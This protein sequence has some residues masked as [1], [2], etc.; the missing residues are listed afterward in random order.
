MK[1]ARQICAILS[2]LFLFLA[3]ASGQDSIRSFSG[4]FVVGTTGGF[5]PLA[6]N[7]AIA[8]NAD[9]IRLEPTL[10]A[11]SAERFKS[12]LARELGLKPDAPWSG[13]IILA[14]HPARSLDDEV[15]LAPQPFFRAWN[16]RVELPDV[17]DRTR[18]ARA[19]TT[20]LL[21]EIANR[22]TSVSGRSVEIPAWLADGLAQSILAGD[23]DQII[24][25]TSGKTVDG[26]PQ[27]RLDEIRHSP[28][29]LAKVHSTLQNFS[30]ATFDQ[31]SWPTDAQLDGDDGGAYHAS[32]QL[33][34]HELLELSNGAAKLRALIHDLP[35]SL[36]WQTAFFTAFH[37]DFKR[38][39]DVEKWWALR[40]VQ[41]ASRNRGPH[42]TPAASRDQLAG[43]LTVPVEFRDSSNSLPTHAEIS[44]QSAI[45]SFD[46]AQQSVVLETKLRDLAL[47]QMRMTPPFA[48]LAEGYRAALADFLMRKRASL[49][50]TLKRLDALD[51]W[52]RAAETAIK[53]DLPLP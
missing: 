33:F 32:T 44:L 28:D 6:H 48:A 41:F 38:P 7:H 4:L 53:P 10:L 30:A 8:T 23:R 46:A 29:P 51:A 43:L 5:S 11:V 47:A 36:N 22:D 24:L 16:C 45:R 20:A 17:I 40:V 2:G 3:A 26:L 9:F 18:F 52:R 1:P 37:E 19:I 27:N 15:F 14:L 35:G 50:N 25:S 42:W 31:L 13:K 49:K 34:V 39:L 12:S 21:L